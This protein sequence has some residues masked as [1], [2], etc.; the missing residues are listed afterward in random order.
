MHVQDARLFV[1]LAI[2]S[3][4]VKIVACLHATTDRPWREIVN[5]STRRGEHGM[6]GSSKLKCIRSQLKSVGVTPSRP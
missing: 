1:A 5:G 2:G 6:H 3:L 4:G